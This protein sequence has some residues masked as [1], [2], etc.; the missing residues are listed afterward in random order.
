MIR[1]KDIDKSLKYYQET[2]GMTLIRTHESPNSGFNLY[3]L[4]YPGEAGAP[5]DGNTRHMEG[6]L[7][8]TWNYGTEKDETF[9]YHNGN[10]EPQGFGHLCTFISLLPCIFFPEKVVGEGGVCERFY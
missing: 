9:K 5:A 6:L 2:L 1:V 3:F 4:G 8:L 10:D 7:E